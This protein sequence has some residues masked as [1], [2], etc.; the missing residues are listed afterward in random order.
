MGKRVIGSALGLEFGFERSGY[1]RVYGVGL[2]RMGVGGG[3]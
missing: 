1:A 2:R 3:L